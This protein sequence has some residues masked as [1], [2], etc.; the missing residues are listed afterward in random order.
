MYS[1]TKEEYEKVKLEINFKDGKP[2]YEIVKAGEDERFVKKYLE[3]DDK[4]AK[5]AKKNAIKSETLHSD[6]RV[7]IFDNKMMHHQMKSIRSE[8]HQI[9]SYHLHKVSLCPFDDKRYILNDGITSYAYGHKKL[10][11]YNNYMT[12]EKVARR[13]IGLG[14]SITNSSII[15]NCIK[16]IKRSSNNFSTVKRREIERIG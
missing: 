13:I 7:V 2:K 8:K 11:S 4:K 5:G 15:D 16:D 6:Y 12:P 14:D 1:Y 9:S 10:I 3:S